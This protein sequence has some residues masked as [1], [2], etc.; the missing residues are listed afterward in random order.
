MSDVGFYSALALPGIAAWLLTGRFAGRRKSRLG[1]TCS[2]IAIC[3]A[4]P[5]AFAAGLC[6][7]ERVLT[8]QD[9]D[10]VVRQEMMMTVGFQF[11]VALAMSCFWYIRQSPSN[12]WM[13]EKK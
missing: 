8:G 4:T 10:F 3:V 6:L 2:G 7:L 5:P 1:R 13:G 9:T 11:P 12:E